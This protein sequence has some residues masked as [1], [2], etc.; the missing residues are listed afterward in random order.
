[1]FYLCDVTQC[2]SYEGLDVIISYFNVWSCFKNRSLC[3]SIITERYLIRSPSLHAQPRPIYLVVKVWYYYVGWLECSGHKLVGVRGLPSPLLLHRLSSLLHCLVGVRGLPSPLLL[4]R[5]SSLLH[6][7]V[8]VRGL[9]SPL[10]LHRLSSLLHCLVGVRGL[11]SPLLL[12]PLS[13]L[14]HCLVGVRGLPSPLLL[15]RLSSLLHGTTGYSHCYTRSHY[16]GSVVG[17][18]LL[19]HY[20]CC[21]LTIYSG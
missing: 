18:C 20:S 9:P 16:L 19:L 6:C 1:M 21:D 14:L 5:L 2:S 12:H 7:L 11:P 4:H 8:G 10:L 13:S 17:S 15:H 3:E